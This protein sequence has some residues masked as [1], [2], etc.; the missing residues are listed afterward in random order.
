MK[1]F[2]NSVVKYRRTIYE[3]FISIID[4]FEITLCLSRIRNSLNDVISNIYTRD[5][6]N[7]IP[8]I[9]NYVSFHVE[10]REAKKR[11]KRYVQKRRKVI[12]HNNILIQHTLQNRIQ[13]KIKR[14]R[15]F[16]VKCFFF[17]LNAANNI[18]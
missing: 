12:F 9:V 17:T 16:L 11:R 8:R 13:T 7:N 5:Y 10:D 18:H 14:F 2:L 4:T 1:Q 15:N 3:P 6:L